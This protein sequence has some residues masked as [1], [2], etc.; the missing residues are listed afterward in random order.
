MS[1]F[2]TGKPND[3]YARYFVGQSYLKRLSTDQGTLGT[4]TFEP[5]SRTEWHIQHARKG[6]GQ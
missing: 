6:G 4:V 1:V 2:P 3:A 5:C